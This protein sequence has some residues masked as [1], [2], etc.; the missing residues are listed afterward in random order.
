MTLF[1]DKNEWEGLQI[2]KGVDNYGM[3]LI[4]LT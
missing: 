3:K 1:E 4:E 2:K